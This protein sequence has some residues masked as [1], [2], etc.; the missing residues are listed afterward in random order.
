VAEKK[1]PLTDCD[2]TI[3]IVGMFSPC[4]SDTIKIA[5]LRNDMVLSMNDTSYHITSFTLSY[6]T[7]DDDFISKKFRGNTASCNNDDPFWKRLD[8]AQAVF[9]DE[10]RVR[11]DSITRQLPAIVK[12]VR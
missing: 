1:K 6:A 9:L 8:E 12:Y 3:S 11:K 5:E 2:K 4:N 7:K 10:V